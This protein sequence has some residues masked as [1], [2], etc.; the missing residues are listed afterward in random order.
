MLAARLRDAH[1]DA[2]PFELDGETIREWIA[3]V[4]GDP[5]DDR[6]AAAA[7]V[8]WDRLLG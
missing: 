1:P 8:E 3:E 4:G 7:I 6:R 2:E 5:D